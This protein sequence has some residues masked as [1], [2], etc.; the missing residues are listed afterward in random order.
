MSETSAYSVPYVYQPL[1]NP[2]DVRLLTLFPAATFSAP[3]EGSLKPYNLRD[4][5]E[6][7]ALSYT[8]G[9]GI[10][11][12][13]LFI[14]GAYALGIAEN[15]DSFLRHHRAVDE[16]K[17]IWVDAICI[18]QSDISEKNTQ[19]ANMNLLYAVA[20]HLIVWLGPASDSSDLAMAT[21]CQLG[22]ASTFEKMEILDS[23]TVLA[24]EKLL[25]R[26]WW[27]RVWVVQ[28]IF[29]GPCSNGVNNATVHCGDASATWLELVVACARIEIST[30]IQHRQTITGLRAVLDFEAFRYHE[31]LRLTKRSSVPVE[32]P[33]FLQL[34]ARFRRF[35]VTDSKDK[36]YALAGILPRGIYGKKTM[37]VAVDYNSTTC[38]AF[39]KF[40]I[41]VLEGRGGL[42]ILRHCREIGSSGASSTPSWVPDWS[43][44]CD[45]M[46]LPSSETTQ[47]AILPWWI[48]P[49]RTVV[50]GKQ[51]IHYS[52]DQE[53]IRARVDRA[54]TTGNRVRINP[55]SSRLSD[56]LP[57]DMGNLVLKLM[58]TKKLVVCDFDDYYMDPEEHTDMEKAAERFMET[59]ELRV[60]ER[61]AKE[62]MDEQ[63]RLPPKYHAA[64]HTE[65]R[66]SLNSS[67]T[68]LNV[69][70]ILWDVIHIAHVP[71][72]KD[73]HSDWTNSTRFMVSLGQAKKLAMAGTGC[74]NP[75]GSLEAKYAAFWTTI[76]AGQDLHNERDCE[77]WLP[78]IP[79][80]WER[81]HPPLTVL[82]SGL[83]E[84]AEDLEVTRSISTQFESTVAT[85]QEETVISS[86]FIDTKP[87]TL[88]PVDWDDNKQSTM[89]DK[90]QE[91]GR[92][93]ECQPYD[94]YH[95]PF[96]LPYVVPDPFWEWR[97]RHDKTALRQSNMKR[98]NRVLDGVFATTPTETRQARNL[99]HA[100]LLK[101]PSIVPTGDS[102]N[103]LEKYALS[104]CFFV[105]S[106]GYFALGPKD[107]QPGDKVV[108]LHGAHVPFILRPCRRQNKGFR[109]V[110]EAYV[111]GI[112]QGE[113]VVDWKLGNREV[114]DFLLV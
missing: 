85:D 42:E 61:V 60:Q 31:Q 46:P 49:E 73:L 23:H 53:E 17:V 2:L 39:T 30:G 79:N 6:F 72:P 86:N 8:W 114:Q 36:I 65:Q 33:E 64:A 5:A 48:A 3:I 20:T 52:F 94:L 90:F 100:A 111:S 27:T 14:D 32:G 43:V 103:G 54:I 98:P 41:A 63:T 68:K 110:G 29:W 55:R 11:V 28:E 107:V 57:P 91:L 67:M 25:T 24:I 109:M 45:E 71:F 75:F 97:R 51:E 12:S 10:P 37:V 44:R 22:R 81:N 50:K 82:E 15:L 1:A 96:Q 9:S 58:D 21:L 13:T 78:E 93:W 7:Q 101:E 34:A 113:V 56:A 102:R 105:T 84:Q 77:Q 47:D 76:F 35:H 40:A 80:S 38:E 95:R 70:G 74:N 104:R 66:F 87:G 99:I 18:N 59:N 83:L 112:M 62:I 88:F 4:F 16:E 19:V 69:E 26:P 89:R 108:V 92:L 106:R